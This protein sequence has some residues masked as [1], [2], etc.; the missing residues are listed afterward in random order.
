MS[1]HHYYRIK[2]RKIYPEC[3]YCGEPIEDMTCRCID[4][5]FEWETCMHEKCF[6]AQKAAIKAEP[7]K[8]MLDDFSRTITTPSQEGDEIPEV[9]EWNYFPGL[10]EDLDDLHI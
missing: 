6:K 10:R 7:V 2:C 1:R 3:C 9:P 8:D 4:P 5:D